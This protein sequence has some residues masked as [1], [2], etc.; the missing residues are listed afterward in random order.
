MA[1]GQARV[2]ATGT[3]VIEL[4]Q[5]LTATSASFD[6]VGTT[7]NPPRWRA[8]G[9]FSWQKG[10]ISTSAFVN[11]TDSYEDN[12]TSLIAPVSSYTTVDVSFSYDLGHQRKSG[13]LSGLTIAVSAQN[14]FNQGPPRL[15]IIDPTKDTGFDPSNASAIGRVLAIE[16]IKRF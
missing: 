9:S 8:R 10:S 3:Y 15:A 4:K 16:L 2:S 6:L 13:V 14:L 7:N 1:G 5:S 12:R 11:Y